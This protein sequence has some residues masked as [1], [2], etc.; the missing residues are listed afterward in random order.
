M[1][2]VVFARAIDDQKSS[3]AALDARQRVVDEREAPGALNFQIDDS[4]TARRHGDGLHA[5]QGWRAEAAAL[6]NVIKN[7]ADEVERRREVRSADA[8]VNA[9]RTTN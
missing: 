9:Y 8:K 2:D 5:S 3:K 1:H 4:R 6:V 7:L